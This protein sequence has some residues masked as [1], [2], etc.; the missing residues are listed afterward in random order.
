MSTRAP[1]FTVEREIGAGAS[2][3]VHL[4]SLRAPLGN[5]PAGAPQPM[6]RVEA[7]AD[8]PHTG[9]QRSDGG[10]TVHCGTKPVLRVYRSDGG[11]DRSMRTHWYARGSWCP[12]HYQARNPADKH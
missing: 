7:E 10:D 4:A 1:D 11:S 5:L 6:L 3:R 9:A 2:A 8:H 12:A